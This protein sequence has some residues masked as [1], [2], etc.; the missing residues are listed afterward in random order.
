MLDLGNP[1]IDWVGLAKSLGVPG[2]QVTDMDQF[3]RRFSEGVGTP[4]PFLIEVVL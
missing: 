4:G 3:N 2:A 1:D